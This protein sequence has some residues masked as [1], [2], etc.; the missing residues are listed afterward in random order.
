MVKVRISDEFTLQNK[1][2]ESVPEENEGVFYKN[3]VFDGANL[4][5]IVFESCHFDCAT[6]KKSKMKEVQFKASEIKNVVFEGNEVQFKEGE[7]FVEKSCIDINLEN[8]SFDNST[9]DF[10]KFS[11]Y[12]MCKADYHYASGMYKV[13]FENA[14]LKNVVFD[15]V[16]MAEACFNNA[17]LENVTFVNC[18]TKISGTEMAGLRSAHF[19]NSRLKNVIFD[20]VEMDESVFCGAVL[21]NVSFTNGTSLGADFTGAFLKNVCFVSSKLRG[22]NFTGV[23]ISTCT[24]SLQSFT[25]GL[26]KK[27]SLEPLTQCVFSPNVESM[28]KV[29]EGFNQIEEMG[30]IRSTIYH[31]R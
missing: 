29:M 10:V 2:I 7:H 25:A 9:L 31:H 20:N 28:M 18:K 1:K 6:F 14:H 4:Q 30:D 5:E 8:A 13:S 22:V 21:E 3:T 12:P 19:E 23:D 17:V 16:D 26:Q 24:F 27:L 11:N 15:S